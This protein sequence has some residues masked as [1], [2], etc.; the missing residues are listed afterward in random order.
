[1]HPNDGRRQK[2]NVVI[3]HPKK[4]QDEQRWVDQEEQEREYI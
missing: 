1:M 4:R 2:I 3:D